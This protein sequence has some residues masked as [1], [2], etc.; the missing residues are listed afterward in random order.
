VAAAKQHGH[1][2]PAVFPVVP[3]PGASRLE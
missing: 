2:E 1:P 3:S